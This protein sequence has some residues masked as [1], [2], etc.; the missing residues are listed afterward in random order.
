[1]LPLLAGIAV[2]SGCD[3][4]DS[5]KE[6]PKPPPAKV[7]C[8]KAIAEDI[9]DYRYYPGITQSVL[10]ADIMARVE[11][12][13]EAMNFIEGDMVKAGQYDMGHSASYYWK[14]KVPETLFFN[15]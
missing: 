4:S 5:T 12:Y 13:L 6:P 3:S 2:L 11:G 8:V 9:P 15:T 7:T 10:E 14:G 1:M